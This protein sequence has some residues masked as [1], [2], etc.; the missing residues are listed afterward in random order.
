MHRHLRRWLLGLL[1]ALLLSAGA[2]AASVDAVYINCTVAEDGA[3]SYSMAVTCRFESLEKNFTIPL[4]GEKVSGVS[5]SGASWA[6]ET[7]DGWNRV[8][9]R[10]S[11]IHI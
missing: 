7:Q 5:V 2:S 3:A 9:L 10:L 1:L 4:A 6:L 11:L 8:V